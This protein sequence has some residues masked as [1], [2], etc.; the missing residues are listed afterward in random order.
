[1]FF[2]E[3]YKFFK[4]VIL[5]PIQDRIFRGCSGMRVPLPKICH[6]YLTVMKL[7][8]VIYILCKEDPKNMNHVT[9]PLSSADISIFHQ[10]TANFAISKKHVRKFLCKSLLT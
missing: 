4:T 9:H 5:N 3:I 10:K 2:W 6:T 1:M 8:T 7:S